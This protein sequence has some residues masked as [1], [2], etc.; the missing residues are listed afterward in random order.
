MITVDL[1][2]NEKQSR[3]FTTALESAFGDND[4]RYLFYGGAIR[5]GKTYG[6]LAILIVLCKI[7][8]GSKWYVIRKSFTNIQETTLPTMTKILRKTPRVKWNRDKANYYVEFTDTG[9][10]IFFA[11][12][13]H[14]TDPELKWMLGLECNGFFL[15]Q[16]EELQE[17]TFNMCISRAGSWYIDKMPTP[18]ILGSFNPTLTWVRKLIYLPH[19]DGLLEA[20]FFYQDAY[21]DDNPFVTEEQWKNWQHMESGMYSQFVGGSWEFAKPPNVF[22]FAFNEKTHCRPLQFDPN[23]RLYLAFDFNVEP[24]TA[25][26]C[27]HDDQEGWIRIIKEFRLLNSDIDELCMHIAAAFPGAHFVVTG[28]SNGNARN[29]LKKNLNYYTAIKKN[30]MLTTLQFKVPRANPIVRNTRVLMNSLFNK[31]PDFAIDP[32]AC[33]YLVLDLNAVTVNEKGE[34]DKGKDK[35]TTHLLDCKRYYEWMFHRNFLDNSLYQYVQND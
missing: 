32:E 21:P 5:G 10:Q 24:I 22:A 29:A 28:D 23:R 27:Q 30:L 2:K 9:S 26:A 11:G 19:I 1:T 12:E 34:I 4:F 35:H 7:F 25:L 17:H 6:C 16:I 33:P 14:K 31:H 18:L 3:F 20:P 13:D 8:P 15:E